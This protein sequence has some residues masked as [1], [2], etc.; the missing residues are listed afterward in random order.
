[1][2]ERFEIKTLAGALKIVGTPE[3]KK[4]MKTF[5][6]DIHKKVKFSGIYTSKED[7]LESIKERVYDYFNSEYNDLKGKISY[8]RK[9]GEEVDFID[10]KLLRVPLKIQ[11]LKADFVLENYQIVLK[12]LTSVEKKLKKYKIE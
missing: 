1:M 4:V 11:L 10:F 3:I 6:K 7:L 12:I 9:H 2:S 5:S 8:L